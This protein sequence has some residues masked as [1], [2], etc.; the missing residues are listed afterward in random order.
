VLIRTSWRPEWNS[1]WTSAGGL[2]PSRFG[3]LVPGLHRFQTWVGILSAAS[4]SR[5]IDSGVVPLRTAK[6]SPLDGITVTTATK[7]LPIVIS[8]VKGKHSVI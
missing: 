2:I 1:V 3:G 8:G 4:I 7:Y 6:P 5:R